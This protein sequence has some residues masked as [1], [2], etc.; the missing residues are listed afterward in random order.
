VTEAMEIAEANSPEPDLSVRTARPQ[1]VS[2]GDLVD[3]DLI[4]TRPHVDRHDPSLI[5]RAYPGEN[6]AL[7]NC[8][9]TSSDFFHFKGRSSAHDR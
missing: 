1:T 3:G 6:V 9:A 2:C 7:V 4:V 8:V 5:F